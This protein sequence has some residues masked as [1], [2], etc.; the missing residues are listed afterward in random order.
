M[1]CSAASRLFSAHAEVIP[2]TWATRNVG[3]LDFNDPHFVVNYVKQDA[4]L[5]RPPR[6]EFHAQGKNVEDPDYWFM[7]ND[8]TYADLRW[9][10]HA[11]LLKEL[12]FIE[13]PLA[14]PIKGEIS[15]SGRRGWKVTQELAWALQNLSVN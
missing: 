3:H 4:L 9:T 13:Q 11:K 12:G 2:L 15:Y 8:S 7:P 5:P 1:P 6:L 14:K 10:E